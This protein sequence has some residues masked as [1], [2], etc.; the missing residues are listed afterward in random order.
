MH[1]LRKAARKARS[2]LA[3]LPY[4]RQITAYKNS[5][6]EERQSY[7]DLGVAALDNYHRYEAL[8]NRLIQAG[9]SV[10]DYDVDIAEF[11]Q[12][13][14]SMPK[15]HDFYHGLG[16]IYIE[17]CLEHYLAYTILG[18][19]SVDIL[20]DVAAASSPFVSALLEQGID[21]Y[22]LDIVYPRGVNGHEIGADAA[23]TKLPAN[24]AD[25]LTL[26]CSFECFA[27]NAD[28]GFI[29]EASRILK[30]G[31]RYAIAPL[32]MAEAHIISKSPYSKLPAKL[33][34]REARQVWREDTYNVPFCRFYAP[35]VFADRVYKHLPDG[36]RGT[37]YF[38]ANLPELIKRY[39]DQKIY[40]YF[41][42]MAEKQPIRNDEELMHPR[43]LNLASQDLAHSL[44]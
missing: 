5:T 8:K 7:H 4:R 15:L 3:L 13:R 2:E 14:V 40:C 41:V 44:D 10:V 38:I 42:F 12:W 33:V 19:N 28:T 23:D 22:K 17:K 16:A 34:D 35:E 36:T 9:V 43:E 18:I 24:F 25:V 27:G 1:L 20:I 6:P 11:T 21:A 37:M 29:K 39:P 30:P 31:G 26:H 32:Y